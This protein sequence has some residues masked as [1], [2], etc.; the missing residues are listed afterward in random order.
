[1]FITFALLAA[2]VVI[3]PVV[4]VLWWA[5]AEALGSRRP[6]VSATVVTIA[7]PAVGSAAVADYYERAA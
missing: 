6:R 5:L 2:A 1:M 7:R 4:W 3:S